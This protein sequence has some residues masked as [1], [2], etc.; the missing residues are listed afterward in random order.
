MWSSVENDLVSLLSA[1]VFHT[2]ADDR[3]YVEIFRKAGFK[4]KLP[5]DLAHAPDTVRQQLHSAALMCH[6]Y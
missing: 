3:G 5:T 1:R 4:G 2:L 6:N